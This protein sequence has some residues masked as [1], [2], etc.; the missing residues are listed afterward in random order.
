M[1]K[2]A[3]GGSKKIP[4]EDEFLFR[5]EFRLELPDPAPEPKSL[6]LP[7]DSSRFVA[8]FFTAFNVSQRV[9][10]YAPPTLNLDFERILLKERSILPSEAPLDS[11]EEEL[12]SVCKIKTT[13]DLAPFKTTSHQPKIKPHAGFSTE[14]SPAQPTQIE[15]PMYQPDDDFLDKAHLQ[16]KFESRLSRF[17]AKS[18]EDAKKFQGQ[19]LVH[20]TKGLK[21]KFVSPLRA[22]S[23]E[24]NGI[25]PIHMLFSSKV[26]AQMKTLPDFVTLGAKETLEKFA[27]CLKETWVHSGEFELEKVQEFIVLESR[28][29]KFPVFAFRRP[30]EQTM[31]VMR[32]PQE[33]FFR[34]QIDEFEPLELR[35][36]VVGEGRRDYPVGK[37]K[38]V[39]NGSYP[40]PAKMDIE[41]EKENSND[42]FDSQDSLDD[43]L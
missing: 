38:T 35:V 43:M 27:N 31:E 42:S 4:F 12:L 13:Q 5:T 18:F 25:T 3:E 7:S 6:F 30:G 1:N 40:I 39:G 34:K 16:K 26:A 41:N 28:L 23:A 22:F 33:Y 11:D 8:P 17:T 36:Q 37:G 29:K 15:E 2:G 9:D 21:A 10:F 19:N 20:P 32:L 14:A 24:A